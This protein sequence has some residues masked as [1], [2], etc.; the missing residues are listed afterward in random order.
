MKAPKL[1]VRTKAIIATALIFAPVATGMAAFPQFRLWFIPSWPGQLFALF[2]FGGYYAVA[3]RTCKRLSGGKSLA[4]PKG[5]R[6]VLGVSLG[7]AMFSWV[8]YQ[9]FCKVIPAAWTLA[10]GESSQRELTVLSV[11]RL[12]QSGM[13]GTQV[14][15]AELPRF[16]AGRGLCVPDKSADSTWVPGSLVKASGKETLLGFWVEQLE[17]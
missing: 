16:P 1:S 11:D 10:L 15:F 5:R 12:H 7:L 14:R 13:C 17:T 4:W 8:G 3:F 6:G 9:A 2:L